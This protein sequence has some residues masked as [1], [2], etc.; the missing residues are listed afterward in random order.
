MSLQDNNS[1]KTSTRKLDQTN[2]DE[3]D[4]NMIEYH[5]NNTN[6]AKKSFGEASSESMNAEGQSDEDDDDNETHLGDV[7]ERCDVDLAD[8]DSDWTDVEA[9]A[10]LNVDEDTNAHVLNS[11]DYNLDNGGASV[12]GGGDGLG[13]INP[14]S[15]FN[16]ESKVYESAMLKQRVKFDVAERP[17]E[18]DEGGDDNKLPQ[19]LS[20]IFGGAPK[21][22]G[23]GEDRFVK[24]VLSVNE[25][26][27]TRSEWQSN[28]GN[29]RKFVIFSSKFFS[30]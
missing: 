29:R 14:N 16:F 30:S 13:E 12:T 27:G 9:N 5:F 28:K 2:Y 10:D 26:L 11:D 7:I 25:E 1:N 18:V 20:N 23:S 17:F 21:S 3:L 6:T 8:L 24:S 15:L 19:S 22:E 4:A